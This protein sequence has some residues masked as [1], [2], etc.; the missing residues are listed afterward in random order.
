[1]GTHLTDNYAE[2]ASSIPS[3]GGVDTCDTIQ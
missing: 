3:T 2:R 1:L